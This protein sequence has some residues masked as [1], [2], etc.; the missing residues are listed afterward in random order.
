[1][2]IVVLGFAQSALLL[3]TSSFAYIFA[4]LKRSKMVRGHQDEGNADMGQSIECSKQGMRA[5]KA[6]RSRG[7]MRGSIVWGECVSEK[8]FLWVLE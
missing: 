2:L 8:L 3:G 4:E 6:V 7:I 1:M 5:R